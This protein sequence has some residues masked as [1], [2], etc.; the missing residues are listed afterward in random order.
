[1]LRR[2][3]ATAFAAGTPFAAGDPPNY[4]SAWS[5]TQGD[6]AVVVGVVGGDAAPNAV[7]TL[8][9][10]LP[11]PDVRSAIDGGADVVLLDKCATPADV[12]AALA[13]GL[14]VI[15]CGALEAGD[16][17]SVAGLVGLMLSCN[18]ALTPDEV[19]LILLQTWDDPY[20]LVYRS[21]CRK[22]PAE[23]VRLMIDVRGDGTVTHTPDDDTYNVGTVV[24]LRA[25]P[26]P[27]WRFARW[28]G[29]C[30]GRRATCTVRLLQ[31]GI[32]TAV[33]SPA[34]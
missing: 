4:Q 21:G 17:A 5:L 20:E 10:V 30:H 14:P 16:P 34:R 9:R 18:P 27:H 13:H 24:V 11:V 33:F 3:L 31:S 22:N 32:T 8:C 29:V 1:M 2:L 19:R 25:K 12:A 26:E 6:P 23:I 15:G 28:Q 7:C